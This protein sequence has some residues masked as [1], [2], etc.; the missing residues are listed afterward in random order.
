MEA[1]GRYLLCMT[2]ASGAAYGLRLMS[3]LAAGGAELHLVATEWGRRV[4]LE[5]TGRA[6]EAHVA[7]LGPEAGG[8]IEIHESG[9]LAACVSSGSF[10]LDGTV[11]APCSMGTL[12]AIASGLSANLAQRAGAVALKEGWPLVL[13]TR[14][15]P[16]SLVSLRNMAALRE[17]GATILPACPGFYNKPQAIG[18][19][20]DEIAYRVIDCL[21]A[22]G[23]GI[24]GARRWPGREREME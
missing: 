22:A 18:D 21:G 16:L 7:S 1:M 10:R 2:G 8:R 12:G 24:P 23:P 5:E 3:L 19:L 15:T 17:S 13:V 4:A 14:E 6:L 20:V 11:I 9:D